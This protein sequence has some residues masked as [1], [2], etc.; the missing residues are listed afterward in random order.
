MEQTCAK[1]ATAICRAKEQAHVEQAHAKQ[2]HVEQAHAKI[3]K[4]NRALKKEL[5]TAHGK[6]AQQ[7]QTTTAKQATALTLQLYLLKARLIDHACQEFLY[8]AVHV[9]L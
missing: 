5:T 4:K 1:Q 8:V 2:A 7:E 6:I 3:T 9:L